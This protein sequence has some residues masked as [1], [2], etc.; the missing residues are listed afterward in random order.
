M[1]KIK[2]WFSGYSQHRDEVREDRKERA[3][4]RA[5]RNKTNTYNRQVANISAY[6]NGIDP[7]A[8]WASSV[9]FMGQ[10]VASIF[11]PASA[12]GGIGGVQGNSDYSG[13]YDGERGIFDKG[14][15]FITYDGKITTAAIIVALIILALLFK[16]K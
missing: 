12:L 2:Q 11:N 4:I 16:K 3:R 14:G 8:A 15:L 7:K 10:A 6:E 1:S 13:Y 9:G 5:D